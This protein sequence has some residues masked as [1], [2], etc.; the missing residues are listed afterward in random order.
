MNKM[1]MLKW[2]LSI[3]AA[4]IMLQTL[5]FK[6]TGHEQSVKLFTELDMEP[7]GRLGI[8]SMELVAAVL[9]LI[10]ATN[11]LGAA[12]GLGLMSGAIFFHFTK[13]GIYFDGDPFLF[14]Y[15]LITWTACLLLLILQHK[16]ILSLLKKRKK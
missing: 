2:L 7:W 1:K 6:F 3:I 5:Y 10:P 12:L 14:V 8:G 13:L 16:Q 15:A 9:L 4:G 11:W